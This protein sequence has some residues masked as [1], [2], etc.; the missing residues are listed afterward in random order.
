MTFSDAPPAEP[1]QALLRIMERGGYGDKMIERLLFGE[2]AP[3][4]TKPGEREF[5]AIL[6]RVLERNGAQSYGFDDFPSFEL[7]AYERRKLQGKFLAMNVL[8]VLRYFGVTWG[9]SFIEHI[10]IPIWRPSFWNNRK[11]E[12]YVAYVGVA[13][14]EHGHIFHPYDLIIS[15]RFHN[16]VMIQ[17]TPVPQVHAGEDYVAHHHHGLHTLARLMTLS[18]IDIDSE[19]RTFRFYGG[20]SRLYRWEELEDPHVARAICTKVQ[21]K[22]RVPRTKDFKVDLRDDWAPSEV[23]AVRAAQ[24]RILKC[25]PL[26]EPLLPIKMSVQQL[27]PS[28]IVNIA[29][30]IVAQFLD[31]RSGMSYGF[32][33]YQLPTGPVEACTKCT[34]LVTRSGCDKTAPH[35]NNDWI[36]LSFEPDALHLQ[37]SRALGDITSPSFD[38]WLILSQAAANVALA[39]KFKAAGRSARFVKIVETEGVA[40]CH[41]HGFVRREAVPGNVAFFGQDR[42]PLPCGSVESAVLTI[43]EK[44]TIA[45]KVLR[46]EKDI[47]YAGDIHV[48]PDHG[49]VVSADF[50]TLERLATSAKFGLEYYES[51]KRPAPGRCRCG[52]KRGL[53]PQC[54]KGM[55]DEWVPGAEA[56]P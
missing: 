45:D 15:S 27:M 28:C 38:S 13:P 3:H 51:Y 24:R 36:L 34:V 48:E 39:R 6:R 23:A 43:Q 18:F 9:P 2:T 53:M 56:E 46:C 20:C 32:L 37:V 30:I 42:L 11:A 31:G 29:P 25:M 19:R 12:K 49:C 55:F 44:G 54:G 22:G 14:A 16:G 17:E 10:G 4:L 35:P 1:E 50:A 52:G 33:A 21:L 5:L 47:D 40:L 7:S 41:F 26:L 8:K